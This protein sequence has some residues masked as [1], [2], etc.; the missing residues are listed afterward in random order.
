MGEGRGIASEL[1]IYEAMH[2]A[3]LVNSRMFNLCFGKDGG[4]FQIGGFN[5]DKMLSPIVW[6]PLW[7]DTKDYKFTLS[8]VRMGDKKLIGSEKWTEGFV[9]TGTTFTYL[10]T[11]MLEELKYEFSEFCSSDNKTNINGVPK[12]PGA[13]H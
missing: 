7:R 13:M 4:F 11:L 9:D 1:P 12:C 2:K 3:K 6:Y 5:Q 8:S 10:P